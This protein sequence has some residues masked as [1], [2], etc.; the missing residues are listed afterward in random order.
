MTSYLFPLWTGS[1]IYLAVVVK[2]VLDSLKNIIFSFN[3]EFLPENSNLTTVKIEE[4]CG[5]TVGKL[6]SLL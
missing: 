6:G 2:L 4:N 1:V 5:T 3:D